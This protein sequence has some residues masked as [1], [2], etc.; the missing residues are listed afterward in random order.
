MKYRVVS[1]DDHIVHAPDSFTKRM[2]KAKW[3]DRIPHI[4]RN[5]KGADNWVIYGERTPNVL[6][7]AGVNGAMPD[8]TK[9]PSRWEDVPPSTYLASERIKAMDQD[10]V[11]VHLLQGDAAILDRAARD[12]FEILDL[13]LGVAAAVGLDIT[14]DDVQAA[15]TER[16]CLLEHLVGLAHS[17]G[18]PDVDAQARPILL[19]DPRQQCVSGGSLVGHGH[20]SGTPGRDGEE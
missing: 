18:G 11:D 4:E 10:G 7:I 12:D 17:G 14:D 5:E 15:R 8:R 13:C 9:A 20:R 2:S 19:L 16:M 6:G 1:T 3:G